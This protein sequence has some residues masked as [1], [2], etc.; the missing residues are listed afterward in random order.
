MK[1]C[2]FCSEQIQESAVK[3]RYCHEFLDGRSNWKTTGYAYGYGWGW[4]YEY[5]SKL[6]F[7]GLPLVHIAQGID[8]NTGRPRVARGI[9]AV[10]NIAIGIIAIGGL[11][12]GGFAFGGMG[13]GLFVIAGIAAGV[14]AFGGMAFGIYIAVG[15]IAVSAMYAMGGLAVAPHAISS[16]GADPEAVR[17]FE[18][19]WPGIRKIVS[20]I[21]R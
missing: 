18:N 7:F 1:T 8:M 2:P 4:G 12:F 17:F 6:K 20:R 21:S 3:C 9:I 10:G 19:W 15:G 14:L 13:L 5:I 11:C 16:M